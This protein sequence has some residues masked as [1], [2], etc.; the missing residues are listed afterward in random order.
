[1][2]LKRIFSVAA[3]GLAISLNVQAL[4]V[5]PAGALQQFNGSETTPLT[6]GDFASIIGPGGVDLYV[7]PLGGSADGWFKDSYQTQF[8][9]ELNPTGAIVSLIGGQSSISGYDSLYLY[10]KDGDLGEPAWY[11]FNI[12]GWNGVE[13]L[14]LDSFWGGR[15]GSITHIGIFGTG[16]NSVPDGG[17]TLLLLSA[18]LAGVASLRRSL[19]L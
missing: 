15:G 19:K 18:G 11:L 4:T 1:M 9:P 3:M 10:V 5:T 14:E 12:T 6:A 16:G 2:E 17:A 8:I 13:S 7:Q